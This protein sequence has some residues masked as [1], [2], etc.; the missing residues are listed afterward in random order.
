M[1]LFTPF[2]RP[3][4]PLPWQGRGDKEGIGEYCYFSDSVD[5]LVSDLGGNFYVSTGNIGVQSGEYTIVVC[6]DPF[7]KIG[8]RYGNQ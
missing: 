1:P 5:N 6:H 8:I 3:H 4:S 2:F 7:S